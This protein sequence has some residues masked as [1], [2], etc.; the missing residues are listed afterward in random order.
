ML[1]PRPWPVV[2]AN[3]IY[4]EVIARYLSQNYQD[5][6][7]APE[8]RWQQEDGSCSCYFLY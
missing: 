2:I 8:F 6:I 4:R 7:P 1:E 5:N 3:A